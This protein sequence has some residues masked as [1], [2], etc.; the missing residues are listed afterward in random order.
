MRALVVEDEPKTAGL[1]RRCLAEEGYAADIAA[2]GDDAICMACSTAY[3]VIALDV[4]LPGRD[5]F[6]VCRELRRQGVWAPVLM[7]TAL[8]SVAHR[9]AGL[10][11]GADDYL[12]KPF[13]MA[14]LLARLRS[15]CRRGRP[16]RPT[17]LRVG[18]LSLDPAARRVRRGD[19]TIE[20][21]AKEFAVLHA[22]MRRPGE[23]LTRL[24]VL[25]SAWDAA[26][27]N[28]SN[29]VDVYVGYLRAKIDTP[30][31]LSCL[32]TVRGHGYRL[33]DDAG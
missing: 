16:E 25:D 2:D 3:D 13:A 22:F 11:H 31:G 20:L 5:G 19:S 26:Y 17:V 23:T 10:D 15:L 6:Q 32:E 27:D 33:G 24:D 4:L 30:F 29:I 12:V 9:V 14:E 28:R 21:S 18:T 1:I 8:D 7:L